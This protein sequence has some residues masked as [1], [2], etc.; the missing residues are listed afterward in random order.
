MMKPTFKDIEN[1]SKP[2]IIQPWWEAEVGDCEFK[3]CLG[4][5]VKLS[6]TIKTNKIHME[7]APPALYG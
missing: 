3:A 4:H 1:D 7:R 6:P 5:I 2:R